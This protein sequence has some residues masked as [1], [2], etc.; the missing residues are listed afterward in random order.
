MAAKKKSAAKTSAK[1]KVSAKKVSGSVLDRIL[2]ASLDE[3]AAIGWRDTALDAI[4]ARA[5]LTLGETLLIVPSKTHIVLRLMDNIDAQALSVVKSVDGDDTPRDRLFEVVMRRFDILNRHRDGFRSII[6]A[7]VRDPAAVPLVLCHLRRSLSAALAAAG[8][9]ADGLR[10]MVR[11]KGLG[12]VGAYALK[13][14]MK[15]DSA[16]L[17]KTMAALDRALAQ[18]ERLA[19]FSPLHRREK[20]KDSQE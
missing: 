12:V 19:K 5:G 4:A 6:K 16:D 8:I 11:I 14:W 15:D 1:R 3:A 7:T 9:S 13:A 17:A 18:A 10:G 2:N 20:S